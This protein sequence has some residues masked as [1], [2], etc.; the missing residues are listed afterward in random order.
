M[1]IGLV[2]LQYSGK[3]TL[4]ETLA[5]GSSHSQAGKEEASI[6]VVKVPDDRLDKLSAIFNPK[7]HVNATIEVYDI[8]GLKMSDDNKV[9]I[10]S[11]FLNA[12]KNNDALFYVVRG[13][14]EDSVMHPMNSINVLR[15]IEFLETEFL[16]TDLAFLETRIEKI[17]KEI[18]KSKDD[19]L[20]R[21]MPVIEKCYAHAEQELPLRSLKL[22]ENEL[23][24]L[25]GYQLLTLKPLAIAINFDENSIA[26]VDAEV[27]A[28]KA[29]IGK[30]HAVIIPFF[31][32]IELELSK[33][34]E[35][36]QAVFM[37]DYGIKE[38]ALS[39]IL[40]TSYEMLGLQS[41]FTVGE[42]ECRAWTIRKNYTAQ[43]AAGV[44]H[45]DF[46]NRF[47]RAEVVS[48]N[49][50][51]KHGSFAKCKDHG[52]WRLEGKEYIVLDGDILNI[53]HN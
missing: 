13:F 18:L 22:D 47:I 3:S 12:V 27:E 42:D 1:Q 43:Q 9:K 7:K 8:P 17:K 14:Q 45:T 35:E 29:K 15:D 28:I 52:A 20:K 10:T 34:S 2:G 46:F 49:D 5:R 24:L 19:R 6:E 40:R 31:A 53:R 36:D 32:K 16:F 33:M 4:F 25:S 23:K 39:K 21:E 37:Q 30:S 38:S 50:F 48:Y 11:T 41:F 44:I 51:M 26:N